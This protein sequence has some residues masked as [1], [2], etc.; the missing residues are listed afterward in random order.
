MTPQRM[1]LVRLIGASDGHPSALQLHS[2]IQ[3]RFPTM[4]Q[5]TVYKTLALLRDM[6]QVQEI[7]L[8][9]ESR[10]DGSRPTPHP[11]LICTHCGRIADGDLELEPATIRRLERRSGFRDLRPQIMFHGL[12]PTC[13]QSGDGNRLA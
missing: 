8:R 7:G 4:S 10:Y 3:Q 2:L 13:T 11:H 12:C 5:A 1:E 9:D 6:G